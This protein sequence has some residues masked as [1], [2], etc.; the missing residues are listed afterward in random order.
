MKICIR[1]DWKTNYVIL[2][3]FSDCKGMEE[4]WKKCQFDREYK[5]NRLYSSKYSILDS[6]NN[7]KQVYEV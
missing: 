5:L 6:E 7:E 4:I 3:K 2:E 1:N